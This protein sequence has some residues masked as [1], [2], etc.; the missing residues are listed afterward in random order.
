MAG[1]SGYIGGDVVKNFLSLLPQRFDTEP[2][3]T[4]PSNTVKFTSM[5][6]IPVFVDGGRRVGSA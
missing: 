3:K 5:K 2:L 6:C 4:V 1:G